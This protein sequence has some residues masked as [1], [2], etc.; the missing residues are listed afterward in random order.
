MKKIR[1][2]AFLIA[3][4]LVPSPAWAHAHLK[5]SDPAA[6]SR[7]TNALL[8][9]RLWFTERPELS[10]TS[11]SLKDFDGKEIA[12]LLPEAG[13]PGDNEIHFRLSGPL[14]PGRYVLAW[15]TAASDGHPS[16]GSIG[17]S[18]VRLPCFLLQHP[19]HRRQFAVLEITP[20]VKYLG[21]VR[22]ESKKEMTPRHRQILLPGRSSSPRFWR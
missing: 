19:R 3:L 10:M 16:R 2:A 9:I 1:Q 5:R 18:V 20:R 21:K 7:V 17:F 4:L 11:A 22:K 8:V 14:S 13:Q 6:G 15:R 12:M